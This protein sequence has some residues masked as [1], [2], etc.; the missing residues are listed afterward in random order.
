ME[1]RDVAFKDPRRTKEQVLTR[2][3]GDYRIFLSSNM[4]A[5][6]GSI[7]RAVEGHCLPARANPIPSA[8]FPS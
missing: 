1:L 4:A 5:C 2:V 8:R 6:R 3:S 7:L